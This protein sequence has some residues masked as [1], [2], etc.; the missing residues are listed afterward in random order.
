[1][2]SPSPLNKHSNPIE[3]L[4][5]FAEKYGV[6]GFIVN[7]AR[8]ELKKLK[9][10]SLSYDLVGWARVNERGD[11]YDPRFCFNPHVPEYIVMSLYANRKE[12]HEKCGKSSK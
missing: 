4:I 1:M 5:N 11:L 2:D 10:Q 8:D 12:Y 3:Y 7:N 6:D 9:D